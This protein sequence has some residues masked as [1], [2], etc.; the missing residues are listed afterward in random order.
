MTQQYSYTDQFTYNGNVYYR[1]AMVD[2]D[3]STHYSTIVSLPMQE[4]AAIRI[5]PTVVTN[6]QLTVESPSSINQAQFQLFD[7]KGQK[8]MV[9]NWSEFQGTQ[10]VAIGSNLAAGAY[11]AYYRMASPY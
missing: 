1:L 9:R 7:M 2:H 6:G 5:Y 11:I 3:G 4:S 8:L 10:Q